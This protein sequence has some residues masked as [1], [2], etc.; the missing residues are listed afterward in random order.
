MI[1][2]DEQIGLVKISWQYQLP[3]TLFNKIIKLTETLKQIIQ[4]F[5]KISTRLGYYI[6]EYQNNSWHE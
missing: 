5:S 3:I 6:S 1:V 2:G 4:G